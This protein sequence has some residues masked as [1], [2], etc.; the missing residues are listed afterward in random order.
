MPR[1]D[2]TIFNVSGDEPGGSDLLVNAVGAEIRAR[3]GDVT[4][5]TA[6][7]PV[8]VDLPSAVI[9]ARAGTVSVTADTGGDN[10]TEGGTIVFVDTALGNNSYD[11]LYGEFQDDVAGVNGPKADLNGVKAMNLANV[12]AIYMKAGSKTTGEQF[13]NEWDF[14]GTDAN[15]YAIF[16]AYYLNNGSPIRGLGGGA[17]PIVEGTATRPHD[18]DGTNRLHENQLIPQPPYQPNNQRAN[19]RGYVSASRAGLLG[20]D[21]DRTGFEGDDWFIQYENI[22]VRHSGGRGIFHRAVHYVKYINCFAELC[23]SSGLRC[24]S[25]DNILYDG[26][27]V[28]GCGGTQQWFNH[29]SRPHALAVRGTANNVTIRNNTVWH[30]WGESTG[31]GQD[32]C[33]EFLIEDNNIFDNKHVHI[34]LTACVRSVVRRNL[35]F[36]TG[37]PGGGGQLKYASIAGQ[38]GPNSL[39]YQG[40]EEFE[41]IESQADK[42]RDCAIYS[43]VVI[44]C[45]RA[46]V[47][48]DQDANPTKGSGRIWD[49]M[50]LSFVKGVHSVDPNF[51]RGVWTSESNGWNQSSGLPSWDNNIQPIGF[52]GDTTGWTSLYTLGTYSSDGHI[53][54]ENVD[55]FVQA[56]KDKVVTL[57]PTGN[58]VDSGHSTNGHASNITIASFDNTDFFNNTYSTNDIGAIAA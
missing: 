38:G 5:N 33:R 21:A 52:T 50:H 39:S 19:S 47:M 37:Y 11:G 7:N 51:P 9:R 31:A 12:T 27:Y 1:S 43:N 6:S 48:Q 16:G 17:R 32:M 24:Q 25:L 46:N 34:Y 42:T 56:V 23:I 53:E 22:H 13:W 28:S 14:K 40:A 30:N 29:N 26:N 15:N 2:A 8:D 58:A 10:L 3:A 35:C 57:A 44:A 45:N 49:N 41:N 18:Y 55:D 36:Q 20:V 4:A 54:I